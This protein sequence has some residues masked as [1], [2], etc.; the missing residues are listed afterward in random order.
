[1][2]INERMEKLEICIAEI[3]KDVCHVIETV[4][5]I[6]TKLSND[7]VTKETFQLEIT[8]L[9]RF[10]YGALGAGAVL[11]MGLAVLVVS[12]VIPGFSL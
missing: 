9:K 1:M 4:E 11:L 2:S 3:R 7:Y 12:R 5:R 10:Y 8:P 6:E